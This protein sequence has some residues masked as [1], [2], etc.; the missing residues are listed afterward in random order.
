GE[1]LL[2]GSLITDFRTGAMTGLAAAVLAPDAATVGIV[3]AGVQART[4]ALALLHALPGLEELRISSRREPVRTELIRGLESE[5]ART[6]SSG[7]RIVGAASAELACR[8]A[9][10]VVAATTSRE[11]VIDDDWIGDAALVCGVGAH[12]PGA[13]ELDARTVARAGVVVVDTARG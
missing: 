2:D 8:D 1:I 11:P 4:Q 13:A 7:V 3:G 5:A 9:D 12:D 6:A 10:V